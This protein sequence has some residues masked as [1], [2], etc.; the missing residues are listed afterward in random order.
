MTESG[1]AVCEGNG[2]GEDECLDA[3]CCVWSGS[4]HETDPNQCHSAV[5]QNDCVKRDQIWP[6]GAKQHNRFVPH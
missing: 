5:G 3:G 4:D 1:Q 2:Y 6:G